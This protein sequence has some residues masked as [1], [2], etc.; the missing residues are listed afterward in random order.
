[1]CVS[2]TV[3][4]PTVV[5]HPTVQHV[6]ELATNRGFLP[7]VLS[8]CSECRG[9]MLLQVEV[10]EHLEKLQADKPIPPQR[11]DGKDNSLWERMDAFDSS[12]LEAETV[13]DS[14]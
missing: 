2:V 1:M 7:Q 3:A 4:Q 6:N 12:I 13:R 14:R 9:S 8:C 10:E 11:M 5:M